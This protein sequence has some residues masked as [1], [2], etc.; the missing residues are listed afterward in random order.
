M[1]IHT[2]QD[3]DKFISNA[4]HK[5]SYLEGIVDVI[6]LDKLP[7]NS[8][9]TF[10]VDGVKVSYLDYVIE[11][12]DKPSDVREQLNSFLGDALVGNEGMKQ[13]ALKMYVKDVHSRRQD[14][15][16]SPDQDP[17]IEISKHLS[18]QVLDHILELSEEFKEEVSQHFPTGLDLTI[19][20]DGSREEKRKVIARTFAAANMVMS[21]CRRGPANFMIV[22]KKYVDYFRHDIPDEVV[23]YSAEAENMFM[24][25]NM[26]LVV[27]PQ[28][29]NTIIIGRCPRPEEPGLHLITTT[30]DIAGTI[31]ANQKDIQGVTTEYALTTT[32]ET[33]HRN[34]LQFNIIE[35]GNQD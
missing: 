31:I 18:K 21:K 22:P 27:S 30:D 14:I 5:P 13:M 8:Y 17:V 16:V 24:T 34:Y 10:P 4:G 28:L 7:V 3:W 9:E 23:F 19:K 25:A 6:Y 15:P 33:A 1:E 2:P 26:K 20:G 12:D 32:G 29:D 35:D 11:E